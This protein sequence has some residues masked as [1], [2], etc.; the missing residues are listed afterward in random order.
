LRT[1]LNYFL[2]RE[3]RH[4]EERR[5][6][7]EDVREQRGGEQ[8]ARAYTTGGDRPTVKSGNGAGHDPG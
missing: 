2:E 3:L 8:G 5:A 1:F 7:Q 4:A 6:R